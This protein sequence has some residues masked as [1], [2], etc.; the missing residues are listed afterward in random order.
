MFR[1]LDHELEQ[2]MR[3]DVWVV[4][5]KTSGKVPA[6]IIGF[7]IIGDFWRD[8]T[9]SPQTSVVI[10]DREGKLYN[11][12]IPHIDYMSRSQAKHI[13]QK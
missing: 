5:P 3:T 9:S 10:M 1:K 7:G 8:H 2:Q 6:K 4:D 11:I 13:G 12:G